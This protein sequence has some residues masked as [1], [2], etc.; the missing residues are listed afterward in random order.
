MAMSPAADAPLLA[1]K[2]FVPPPR[3]RLVSRD[4]LTER[5]ATM[6]GG[7][8]TLIAAAA[9]WGKSTLLADWAITATGK[10]AWLSLDATDDEPRRFLSYVIAALRGAGA[11]ASEDLPDAVPSPAEAL[12]AM[13]VALLN[14]ITTRGAPV[15]LVL[16]DYHAIESRAVHDLV[17]FVIDNLPPNLHLLLATRV[18]PPLALS[19]LRARG[20]LLELRGND[21][22][23]T[24]DEASAFLNGSMGL[25]LDTTE[26][27]ELERRT[28]GWVVGLQMAAVSLAGRDNAH[29]FITRFSGS[30]RFV[31]D[32]LTDEVLDRQ[33]PDVRRFLLATSILT[34][35]SPA[36]CDAVVGRT[37][38]AQVLDT[39]DVANLFLIPLDDVRYWYRYH[40]LFATLLQH[41]LMRT[42]S[43]NEIADLHRRASE[44]YL[45]QRM[46]EPALDHALA[47]K[48]VERAASILTMHALPRTL[49]GDA[50][51]AVRWFDAMPQ[52]RLDGDTELLLVR[53]VAYIADYQLNRAEETIRKLESLLGDTAPPT[54]R[55]A[56]LSLRGSV[57]R[58][59]GLEDIGTEDLEQARLLVEPGT[60]WSSM[61]S[62]QL[63]MNKMREA[64]VPAIIE[65][66]A[67]AR[68]QHTRVEQV[69]IAVLAQ[70]YT[71]YAEWWRGEPERLVARANEMFAW[72]DLTESVIGGR[73]L[74][75][76]PYTLLAEERLASNDL[77]A[78]RTFAEK[79]MQCGRNGFAIGAF[80]AM[81]AL[82]RVAEAER[83]WDAAL[84]ATNDA[85]RA[86]RNIAGTFHWVWSVKA[87]LHRIEFRRG[88]LTGNRSDIERALHW[89]DSDNVVA[90][91]MEWK[92]RRITGIHCDTPL[93]L[94][95]RLFVESQRFDEALAILD[96]V[97]PRAI[98]TD[99]QRSLIEARILRAIVEARAGRID[100]GVIAMRDAL[101]MAARHRAVRLVVDEGSAIIPLIERAAPHIADRDFLTRV[102]SAFDVPIKPAASNELLSERELEVLRIVAAGASNQDAARKLFIAPGTVKKHLENIYAKLDVRGRTE[103]IARAR[104][105]G[106][107]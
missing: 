18:D 88:Q 44:W 40:H 107:I 81:R 12:R 86:I 90:T 82:A 3:E 17:Q 45:T 50:A 68:A 26:V 41:Q 66:L 103:A 22:R 63:G 13:T 104:E 54:Q 73:P 106:M 42:H 7:R 75:A 89:I 67:E 35:L 30:H 72:I 37:D 69:I 5:L 47:A 97:E 46:P 15:S 2:L 78:A 62:Y 74:D 102:L 27:A 56:L 21:L 95:V 25:K 79:A 32:Y 11:L 96:E 52:G 101:T 61:V 83:D 55:G 16:D 94:A 100:K 64:D 6:R 8:V 9:G 92:I 99:R 85:M 77:P 19:R 93:F 43:E 65:H 57:G 14:A 49:S 33:S 10:V 51:S 39:L 76:F 34:R 91:L 20:L 58:M 31:L 1:T 29:D 53:C 87:L 105:M 71:A 4:R 84:S 98:A 80:E 24:P 28:E 60:F 48:D 38:S 70:T 23:F 59:K 36:L